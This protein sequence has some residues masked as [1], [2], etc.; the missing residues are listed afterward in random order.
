MN[1]MKIINTLILCFFL[2]FSTTALAQNVVIDSLE[3]ELQNHLEK[4]SVRVN[5]LNGLASEFRRKDIAKML[6]YINKAETLAEDIDYIG[7]KALAIY[8]RGVAEMNQSNFDKSIVQINKAKQFYT[9]LDDNK[10]VSNCLQI[11]GLI[12]Y[13]QENYDQAIEYL[14]MSNQMDKDL[15]ITKNIPNNLANIANVYSIM[16]N[17]SEAMLYIEEAINSCA[18]KGDE[19]II[20]NCH[21]NM[22]TIYSEQGNYQLAQEHIIKSIYKFEEIGDS[23]SIAASLFNIAYIYQNQENYEKAQEYFEQSLAI[24]KKFNDNRSIARAKGALATILIDQ[25]KYEMAISLLKESIEI[26]KEVNDQI[27]IAYTLNNLGQ[28]SLALK[29]YSIALEYFL[30]AKNIAEEINLPIVSSDAYL[31]IGQ[32]YFKQQKYDKSLE[33]TLRSLE[34]AETLGLMNAKRNA[35]DLLHEIYEKKGEYEKAYQSHKQFKLLS[36]SLFNKE[37]IQKIAQLENEYKYQRELDEAE[38]REVELTSTV[39]T[40]TQDLKKSQRNLL[41]GVIG[42]L[43]VSLVLGAIIFFLKL[44]HAKSKTQNIVME[45]KLL[46]SQMTPHFVFNSLSVLQGMILNKEDKKS[47]SYLSKF[48]KLLRI[49]L[50]N[51]R[52]KTVPLF[53]ELKAIENYLE[54]QNLEVNDSYQYAIS[55]DDTLDQSLFKIPPMLIQPFIENAIEHAFKDQKENRKIDVQLEYS[56]EELIC[57]ITDNGIGVDTQKGN[58]K[59]NKKSLATT[60]TSERLEMLSKDFKMKGA[61]SIEDRRKYKEQG[62]IVSLVIPYI[63]NTSN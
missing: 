33:N 14:K 34:Y 61:I 62:T 59:Q 22:A 30:E 60:I 46:R 6:E 24:S 27:N 17:Y 11:T 50:E 49:T 57:T 32:T 36:D 20:A 13:Y 43:L 5:L 9:E 26:S 48:S 23:L 21:N 58:E 42:F 31:G 53:Q 40:T 19:R 8:L 16:G 63:I 10:G 38:N 25:E 47:I 28:S 4:D 56:N 55:V 29:N 7:G 18:E 39:E 44:R 1:F 37:S 52:D 2:A 45:Q 12:N 3:N 54:L 51:S 15:G 41:L 35:N